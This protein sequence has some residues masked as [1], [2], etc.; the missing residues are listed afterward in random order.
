VGD[1]RPADFGGIPHFDVIKS[2][3]P[4]SL[5]LVT[6]NFVVSGAVKLYNFSVVIL[7]ELRKFFEE[8]SVLA[9]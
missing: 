1:G 3:T 4:L 2:L 8:L 5:L 6:R 7:Q 9:V